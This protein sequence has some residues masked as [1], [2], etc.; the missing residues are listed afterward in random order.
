MGDI[1]T[2]GMRCQSERWQDGDPA[3]GFPGAEIYGNVVYFLI[4]NT[5]ENKLWNNET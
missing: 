1:L 5:L 2:I 4:S 3:G